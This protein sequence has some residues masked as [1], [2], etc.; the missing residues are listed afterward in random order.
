MNAAP[1]VDH[2]RELW[3]LMRRIIAPP[4]KRP[5]WQ[6]ADDNIV[7][8]HTAA[9]SGRYDSSL[10]P[11]VRFIF[12]AATSPRTRKL[13]LLISAQSFKSQFLI[14]FFQ[15]SLINDPGMA[16]WIMA[17]AE[18]CE[19]FIETRLKRALENC[20]ATKEKMPLTRSENRKDL[21]QFPSMDLFVRGSNSRSKLQSWPIRRVYC[22]ERADWRPGAIDD[23]RKRLLTFH[24][25]LEISA[26]T[27]GVEGDTFTA[28][29]LAGSQTQCHFRCLACQHSQ[30][31]RFGRDVSAVHPFPRAKGGLRWDT[32]EV[33]KPGGVWDWEAVKKTARWECEACGHA[34]WPDDKPAMIATTHAVDHN[35]GASEKE[36]S[37]HSPV[38]PMPWNDADWRV[39]L[40]EFLKAMEAKAR[41]DL[42]P[43]K[44]FVT[45]VLCEPWR[46]SLGAVELTETFDL[47]REPYGFGE[48]WPAE[49]T[50]FMG[51]DFQARGGDHFWWLIRAISADGSRRL[52]AYGRCLSFDDLELQRKH[53]GVPIGNC[54]IDHGYKGSVVARFC[55]GTGWK[56]F[57]GEEDEH[58]AAKV[59]VKSVRRYWSA[60]KI[61][62]GIGLARSTK[63][64]ITLYRWSNPSFKDLLANCLNG[65]TP[66]FTVPLEPG[67]DWL[68]HMGAEQRVEVRR[69]DGSLVSQWRKVRD[70]DH[71]R[72][73]E[74]MILAA[75]TIS[76]HFKASPSPFGGTEAQG[77]N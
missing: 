8:D 54:V 9:L 10:T 61:N 53:H 75:M 24:N 20:L 34:H 51:V 6:W 28:D 71:L 38:W 23:V 36:R 68:T 7:L 77:L 73:C 70:D 59:G 22:D 49:V 74:L 48:K 52:I 19:D 58:F 60:T 16:M 11:F 29:Y 45:K 69:G 1:P 13:V 66:G 14:I 31:W 50:R 2:G 40:V 41:G 65:V 76:A 67:K 4:D 37:F 43:L 15:W 12:E 18:M 30:P 56:P 57:K 25:S 32:N 42:D 47:I 17:N 33:T 55:A 64:I 21:V 5:G 72:D 62:V 26:G 39:K 63:Q 44:S 35:P 27:A 3:D 46:D